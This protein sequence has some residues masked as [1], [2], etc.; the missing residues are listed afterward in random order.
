MQ[1]YVIVSHIGVGSLKFG[2]QRAE[3]YNEIGTP[4]RTRKSRFSNEFT[5]FWYDNGLQLTFSVEEALLEISLY[6]NLPL[7][8][9]GGIHLFEEPGVDVMRK[10]R[11]LDHSPL[12]KAGV[13]IFLELGLAVTGFLNED[14]DQ[15]SVS[16]F[17]E[18]RWRPEP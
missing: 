1:R 9:F 6:P 3:I 12:E 4:E 14:D 16:V 17:A 11:N 13:T 18:G 7:V 10:L 8:E 2:M 5:E 15:K